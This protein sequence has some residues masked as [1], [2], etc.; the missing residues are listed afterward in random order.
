MGNRGAP[1]RLLIIANAKIPT[2]QLSFIKPLKK[3]IESGEIFIEMLTE[4]QMKET[5]GKR[6]KASHVLDWISQRITDANP[7][8]AIFCRYSGPNV[9]KIVDGVNACGSS[10]I[11]HIDDD[12]LNVPVE[13]GQKK[14]FKLFNEVEVARYIVNKSLNI[15]NYKPLWNKYLD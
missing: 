6:L 4:E 10:I 5:F 7:T 9:Q 11:F 2:V 3:Y 13:I 1:E 14:Y 8:T 12:L 15:N